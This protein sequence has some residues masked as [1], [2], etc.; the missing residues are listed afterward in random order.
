M[1][2]IRWWVVW[3]NG[4]WNKI[5]V[6]DR[7][8]LFMGFFIFIYYFL[9]VIN[10]I[11]G[12]KRCRIYNNIEYF[13]ILIW[14]ILGLYGERVFLFVW[15]LLIRIWEWVLFGGGGLFIYIKY[16]IYIKLV[17]LCIYFIL[18]EFLNFFVKGLLLIF[19]WVI[20]NKI[21]IYIIV[22]CV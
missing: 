5:L 20:W 22:W 11:R 9:F 10:W 19:N 7:G 2:F 17:F 8:V 1:Y 4:E 13:Y 15:Y 3:I 16:N 18:L 12:F 21:F 6:L 14:I